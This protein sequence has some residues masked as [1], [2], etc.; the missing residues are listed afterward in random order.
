MLYRVH[1]AMI[2]FELT[3]FMIA[4]VVVN[5]TT[6]RAQPCRPIGPT[7]NTPHKH[8]A[9]Q[10]L[11]QFFYYVKEI[12]CSPIKEHLFT[13]PPYYELHI[14][15]HPSTLQREDRYSRNDFA[16]ELRNCVIFRYTPW[17]LS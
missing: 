11:V 1:L 9:H 7:V 14:F 6:M 5:P 12:W 15:F 8:L 17:S 2:G 13:V 10:V 4:Q 3:T 16:Q